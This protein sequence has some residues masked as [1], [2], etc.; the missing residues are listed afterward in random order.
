MLHTHVC[1]LTGAGSPG[2]VSHIT[3]DHGGKLPYWEGQSLGVIPP[4]LDASGKAHK[5]YACIY[6]LVYAY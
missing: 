3:I 5:V 2:E 4:G 1:R 6:T